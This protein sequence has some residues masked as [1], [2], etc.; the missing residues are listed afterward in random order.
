MSDEIS[1]Y[2]DGYFTKVGKRSFI[3]DELSTV[4]RLLAD[5]IEK[6]DPMDVD[7]TLGMN[8]MEDWVIT[9][10]YYIHDGLE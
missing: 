8:E 2:T 9:V 6:N 4:L 7:I 5:W 3:A 10:F 1:P